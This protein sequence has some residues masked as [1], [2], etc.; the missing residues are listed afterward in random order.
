MFISVYRV[1]YTFT[2]PGFNDNIEGFIIIDETY[3]QTGSFHTTSVIVI[4][5]ISILQRFYAELDPSVDVNAFPEYYKNLDVKDLQIMG[6]LTKSNSLQNSLV[7]GIREAGYEIEYETYFIVE[8]VYNILEE[9][10]LQLADRIVS[11]DGNTDIREAL[12]N[13]GCDQHAIFKIIRDGEEMTYRI[14]RKEITNSSNDTQCLF[15]LRLNEYTDIIS[16]EVDY[17]LVETNTGGSSGGLLQALYIYNQITEFDIT[18]GLKI[19]GTGTIDINGNVGSIGGIEQKV[20]TSHYNGIDV[21]FVPHLTSREND[22]YLRALAR[23]NTIDSD[24]KIVPVA[25]FQDAL[26]YLMDDSNF[27]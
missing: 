23:F 16:T 13:V 1:D 12:D 14:K 27:D 4:D 21:F 2:T 11:I 24:M 6:Y 10:T 25:S 8:L 18:R 9:D 7:V 15:G 17:K 3:P 5:K 19:A 26:D 20:L 22:N